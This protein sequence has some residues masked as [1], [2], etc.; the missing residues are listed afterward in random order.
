MRRNDSGTAMLYTLMALMVLSIFLSMIYDRVLRLMRSS[1]EWQ[2]RE[3]A[4]AAAESG[5]AA[6]EARLLEQPT[7]SAGEDPGRA[8]EWKFTLDGSDIRVRTERFRIPDIVWIFSSS[9]HK[10]AKKEVVRP[11]KIDD[12]TLFALMARRNISLGLGSIVTGSIYASHIKLEEGSE[13]VESVI[14]S[15]GLDITESH[16]DANIFDDAASPP[17]VPDID[18]K[19]LTAVWTQPLM[20]ATLPDTPM[21]P[22]RYAAAG[23]LTI[24]NASETD[25]SIRVAGNLR[26]DGRVN[27]R[28]TTASDTP[29]LVVGKDLT[30]TLSG[31]K[32]RGVIFVAGKVTLK[33][34]GL[35]TGMIIADE[36]DLAAGVVVQSF[37]A[38]PNDPR[39]AASFCKRRVRR[40]RN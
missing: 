22:G 14:S 7:W 12:P 32:I 10:R 25:V 3:K 36:I 8:P 31:A 9:V 4:Q 30:G 1:L 27:L 28:Y 24:Q 20:T 38:L 37:D 15:G 39:P 33:G 6:S 40:V 18:L 29:I 13:V 19:T 16:K 35:I 21:M 23:D 5:S 26:L 2:W 34:E 17:E 11:L